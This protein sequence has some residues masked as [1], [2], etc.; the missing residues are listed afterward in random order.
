[1]R[2]TSSSIGESVTS[3]FVK[4]RLDAATLEELEDAL[5][6]ADLGIETAARIADAIGKGRYDREIAP[7]EVR[8]ILA[9]EV[10]AALAPAAKPLVVDRT[11]KPFVI[12]MIG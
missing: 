11:K 8:R 6:R 5:V 12:L 2:R 1:M 7:D 3:L 10:E 9:A 4:R